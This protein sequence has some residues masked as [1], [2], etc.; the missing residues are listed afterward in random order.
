MGR[1]ND[2]KKHVS[3]LQE[4][5]EAN[6]IQDRG[7]MEKMGEAVKKREEAH[8]RVTERAEQGKSPAQPQEGPPTTVPPPRENYRNIEQRCL[9]RQ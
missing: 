5:Q 6:E 3:D 4:K 8:E 7:M 1:E 2:E 9:Q